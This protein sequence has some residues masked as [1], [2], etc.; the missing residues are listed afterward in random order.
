MWHGQQALKVLLWEIASTRTWTT[1]HGQQ[2]CKVWLSVRI[3]IRA[4]TMET[5]TLSRLRSKFSPKVRHKRLAGNV[6]LSRLLTLPA[7]LL[8]L[9][10]GENFD[11]SLDNVTWPPGLK[12]LALGDRFNQNLDNVTWPAGLEDLTFGSFFNQSL[13]NVTWPASLQSL[14]FG[15][16]FKQNLDNVTWPGGLQNLTVD[17]FSAEKLNVT[18]PEGL[19]SLSIFAFDHP[20][21]ILT[22]LEDSTAPR[23]VWP[24]ALRKLVFCNFA[25]VCWKKC[26]NDRVTLQTSF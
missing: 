22:T 19:E 17:T 26:L 15:Q 25:L 12:S 23:A 7:S 1:W 9:T 13:D 6:R 18:W 5:S 2:A 11:R 4:W 21:K 14:A 24:R 3:S 20:E 8:C 16:G 10:F